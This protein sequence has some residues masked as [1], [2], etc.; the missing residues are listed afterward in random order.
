[1]KNL[2]CQIMLIFHESWLTS[3]LIKGI[4]MGEMSKVGWQMWLVKHAIWVGISCTMSYFQ[5]PKFQLLVCACFIKLLLYIFLFTSHWRGL[6]E[7]AGYT[8]RGH[9]WLWL[10]LFQGPN[11]WGQRQIQFWNVLFS[12]LEYQMMVQVKKAVILRRSSQTRWIY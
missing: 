10:A 4:Q 9:Q 3:L 11:T 12:S 5:F 1:M 2:S 8:D 7:D 6:Y